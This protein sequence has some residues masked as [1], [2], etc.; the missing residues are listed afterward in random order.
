MV[1]DCLDDENVMLCFTSGFFF[2]SKYR[3]FYHIWEMQLNEWIEINKIIR[4][5]DDHGIDENGSVTCICFV[6]VCLFVSDVKILF[7]CCWWTSCSHVKAFF[8]FVFEEIF[9]FFFLQFFGFCFDF[10]VFFFVHVILIWQSYDDDDDDWCI[11]C[12]FV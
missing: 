11:S 1:I 8:C 5:N 10:C 3:R 12:V 4:S 9:F 2:F 7:F 6:F